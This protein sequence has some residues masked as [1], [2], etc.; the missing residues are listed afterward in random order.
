VKLRYGDPEEVGMSGARVR[1]LAELAKSWVDQGMTPALVVLVARKGVIVLHEAFGKLTTDPESPA[2]SRDAIYPIAS[3]S[4][5]FTATAVMTLVDDGLLGLNRPVQEYVPDFVGEGKAAVMVHHLLTHTSGIRDDD[6]V[7][8]IQQKIDAGEIDR[9]PDTAHPFR[10]GQYPP[11]AR[12]A[13]LSYRPGTEMSYSGSGYQVLGEIVRR[14]AGQR[15]VDFARERI[16]N[17]LG[18]DEAFYSLPDQLRYR[19]VHRRHLDNL[20][21]VLDDPGRMQH[22]GADGGMFSTARDLAVFGQMYLNWGRYGD[23][24][25]LSPAAVVEM[26]RDQIPGVPANY[27]ERSSR[28]G[29]G[30][31]AGTSTGARFA[32]ATRHFSRQARSV[33]AAVAAPT[34]G[35]T[36]TISSLGFISRSTPTLASGFSRLGGA[37]IC[38]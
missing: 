12:A 38:S 23:A 19:F 29:R 17:P 5:L 31:W 35:S 7:T 28:K 1:R 14:V 3:I 24:R 15:F 33:T 2:V 6:A 32:F 8:C 13:P 16:L 34:S 26:T 36:R 22:A 18:L 20:H 9:P 25:I 27:N 30:A 10:Y 4:K 21:A 37:G 11:E